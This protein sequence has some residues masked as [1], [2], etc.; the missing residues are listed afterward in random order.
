ML[1][2]RFNEA[3]DSAVRAVSVSRG[4]CPARRMK[5]VINSLPILSLYVLISSF[6]YVQYL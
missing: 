2:Q 5:V 1:S 3:L 4:C 6:N